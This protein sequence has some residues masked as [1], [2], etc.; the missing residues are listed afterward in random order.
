MRLI[1]FCSA[2]NRLSFYRPVNLTEKEKFLKD[3]HLQKQKEEIHIKSG[4]LGVFM[5][6]ATVGC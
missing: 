3:A 2:V 5:G 4:V 6:C 1:F